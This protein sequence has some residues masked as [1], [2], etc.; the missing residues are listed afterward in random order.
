MGEIQYLA[1]F[2]GINVG[3]KNI[4]KMADL[5][6]CFESLGFHGVTTYIQ[7]GNVIF[8]TA[9]RNPEIL[10]LMIEKEAS[11]R[12]Q[13]ALKIHL[14][15]QNQIDDIVKYKPE[16]FGMDTENYK[17]DVVFLKAPLTAQLAYE[18]IKVKEGVDKAY[19]GEGVLYLMRLISKAGQSYFSKVISLPVY[20]NMTVRNWNTTI[21]LWEIMNTNSP[22]L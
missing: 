16:G 6:A 15:T 22:E 17:Y 5:K 14:V 1:L 3:G 12:F 11:V 10:T 8:R 21:K 20:Q 2:R 13:S 18:S 4:I 7:S 19:A 9:E